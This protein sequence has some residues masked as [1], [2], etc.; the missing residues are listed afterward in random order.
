M[1]KIFIIG[2]PRTG[3]TSIS[4]ALLDYGFKV[5]H[6]AYTKRAFEVADVI[7]DS[8]CFSDYQQ[9]DKL[10]PGSKFVY[11]ERD[12]AGW[13]PSIQMLLK[14]MQLNLDLK[15]GVFNPVMKRSF[16]AI[17]ALSTAADPFN[18]DYLQACYLAHKRDVMDYFSA[19]DD[20]L[21]INLSHQGS[22]GALLSFIEQTPTLI[23]TRS[24]NTDADFTQ[25][26]Y[27]PLSFPHLNKG[28][29]V[30][31]WREY[32]HPNKVNPNSAGKD[33]RQFFD[34]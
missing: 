34:Y 19:R 2:L 29:H 3:T 27:P 14:K 1:N 33:R 10:F 5:A 31:D 18:A 28:K 26:N 24:K 6:T 16:N 23:S 15:T 7:S 8:P 17:F 13:L 30:A 12:L 4:V 25:L 11:L 9:L 21:M 32:K 22:L 20:L